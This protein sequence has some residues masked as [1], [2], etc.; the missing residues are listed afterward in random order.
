MCNI[1]LEINTSLEEND[2]DKNYFALGL[3][4]KNFQLNFYPGGRNFIISNEKMGLMIHRFKRPL[5]GNDFDKNSFGLGRL[6]RLLVKNFDPSGGNQ[7]GVAL[8]CPTRRWVSCAT[9]LQRSL[10][11]NDYD[12]NVL[13]LG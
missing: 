8:K 6:L 7:R 13:D 11:N 2:F 12:K 3:L 5:Q 1:L 4:L 9:L 10:Q